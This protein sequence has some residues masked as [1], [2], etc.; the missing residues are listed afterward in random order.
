[1]NRHGYTKRIGKPGID[2]WQCQ[3]CGDKGPFLELMR[4]ECVNSY[5]T[6]AE[7]E[8]NILDAIGIQ[9]VG[10]LRIMLKDLYADGDEKLE[11]LWEEMTK[12]GR[13]ID[14]ACHCETWPCQCPCHQPPN[15]D[16]DPTYTV[17]TIQPLQSN[18]PQTQVIFKIDDKDTQGIAPHLFSVCL[19]SN[20]YKVG[21]QKTLSEL[22]IAHGKEFIL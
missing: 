4:R 16:T 18:S 5:S 13:P 15:M 21:D 3:Q 6:Q 2:L 8:Q 17:V 11:Q 19:E 9:P 12:K 20:P 22:L 1:M 7:A 10:P 14:S